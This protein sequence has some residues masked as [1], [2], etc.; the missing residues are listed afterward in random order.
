MSFCRIEHERGLLDPEKPVA[1]IYRDD[2]PGA[3][4][5]QSVEVTSPRCHAWGP[6]SYDKAR[7]M[8]LTWEGKPGGRNARLSVI[9]IAEPPSRLADAP[10]RVGGEG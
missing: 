2:G 5:V 7:E 1:V 8:L 6:M 10:S 3:P 4:G 9:N